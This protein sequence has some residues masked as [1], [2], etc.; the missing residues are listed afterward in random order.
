MTTIQKCTD[1]GHRIYWRLYF[2]DGTFKEK[3]KASRTKR[4]LQELLPE[5]MKIESLS[6]RNDLSS[7]DLFRAINLKLI[8]REDLRLL[9]PDGQD[10]TDHFIEELRADFEIKSKNESISDHSHRSNLYK[11][12][13]LEEYFKGIPISQITAEQIEQ[14]RAYRKKTVTNTTINHDIKILRKYLDIAVSKHFVDRNSA[15]EIKLLSEPKNRIP[16]CFYPDEI[17]RLLESMPSFNHLL[18]G[19]MDFIVR[20]LIHTG[21]RRGELCNLK[22]QNI[23]LHLRQI[24]LR[25]KGEKER[26]VGI[27]YSLMHELKRRVENGTIIHPSIK[28]S[29]ITHAFK[30]VLRTLGLDESLTL[31]SLRHTFISYLLEKGVPTKKVKERAGHFSLAV[32]DG[33]THAIP[34]NDVIEDALDFK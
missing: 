25:G 27:H 3:Y 10:P 33:Y 13:I 19:D 2:P 8:S 15:R 31:H 16:R 34:S 23:K 12:N 6:R 17:K 14:F 5:A 18:R 4:I 22:P 7:S 32:T 28:P 26:V 24:H 1:K 30:K 20:F 11:A 9:S 21:L 29:S